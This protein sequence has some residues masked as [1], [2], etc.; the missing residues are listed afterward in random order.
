METKNSPD[1]K[2]NWDCVSSIDGQSVQAQCC[3]ENEH[4][5]PSSPELNTHTTVIYEEFI[6]DEDDEY[7]VDP[8][9]DEPYAYVNENGTLVVQ[10]IARNKTR[11]SNDQIRIWITPADLDKFTVRDYV[12][13]FIMSPEC[14]DNV[15]NK[16]RMPNNH[17][18]RCTYCNTGTHHIKN[19]RKICHLPGCKDV[20]IHS[21]AD[22]HKVECNDADS[23]I[24]KC[25]HGE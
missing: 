16:T 18:M 22:W 21:Y 6:L 9:S 13:L 5:C 10:H 1:E 12:P 2:Q 23:I 24:D 11:M 15:V 4:S 7:E 17:F 19:C 14:Y 3:E 20:R 25:A 8:L